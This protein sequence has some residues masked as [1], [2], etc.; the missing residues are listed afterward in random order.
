M[1]SHDE[2]GIGTYPVGVLRALLRRDRWNALRQ[3]WRYMTY[4]AKR[5]NW[6]AIRNC[7]N[8]Y[9]AEWHY[10]PAELIHSRCG[11]GWTRRAALRSLGRHLVKA[12][13]SREEVAR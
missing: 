12:N 2:H 9:M 7:F 11:T 4:Q 3:E 1:S 6:R 8:G 10:P 13:L 5:R